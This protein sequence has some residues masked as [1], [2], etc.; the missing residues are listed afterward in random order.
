MM[1][2]LLTF[3]GLF[4]VQFIALVVA[5]S[6]EGAPAAWKALSLPLIPLVDWFA[7]NGI[8]LA[9]TGNGLLWS[10]VIATLLHRSFLR[11]GNRAGRA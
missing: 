7:E 9:I 1:K 6:I 11:A 5:D 3:F 10:V 4:S 2:S 8:W